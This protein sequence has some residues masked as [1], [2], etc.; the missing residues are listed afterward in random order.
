M[1]KKDNTLN[2]IPIGSFRLCP[3]QAVLMTGCTFTPT[4]QS[5]M[6]M[7]LGCMTKG[8]NLCQQT[9]RK[10]QDAWKRAF[11]QAFKLCPCIEQITDLLAGSK[12]S[13]EVIL[14]FLS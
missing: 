2:K 8:V 10:Y 3:E 5:S 9:D 6:K 1:A 7:S 14:T 4:L 11:I 12:S 13:N